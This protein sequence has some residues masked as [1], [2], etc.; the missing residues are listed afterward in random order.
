MTF[1][2]QT[3]EIIKKIS[4]WGIRTCCPRTFRPLPGRFT[5]PPVEVHTSGDFTWLETAWSP[6][7][8]A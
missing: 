7:T 1:K 6:W 5:P 3:C 8:W 4:S 2:C